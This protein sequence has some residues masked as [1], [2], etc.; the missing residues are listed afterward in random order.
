MKKRSLVAA[1]AMLMVS[2]IV[3]T[4]STY[5]WFATNNQA[6][7]T[8]FKADVGNAAGSVYISADKSNWKS[9]LTASDFTGITNTLTPVSYDKEND[10]F[11]GGSFGE[12]QNFALTATANTDFYTAIEIYVYAEVA[13]TVTITPT[14][15]D[16]A[17]VPY[18]YASVKTDAGQ[19]AIL[20]TSGDK[21]FPV[22]AADKM[23]SAT[24]TDNNTQNGIIDADEAAAGNNC[25]LGAEVA[26]DYT[27]PLTINIGAGVD[28]AQKIVVYVW[29][30]GQD[31]NCV[32]TS[33]GAPSFGISF[34][35]DQA[36]S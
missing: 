12:N 32:G 11:Y 30:E 36:D 33:S 35:Y 27:T 28:N 10:H 15:T 13:G 2:A 17:N 19:Q 25:A 4:S 5:A 16:I 26:V 3:L 22:V 8:A 14:L 23:N 1:L 24:A 20:G 9:T 18:V 7:L 6:S 34:A 21:Y 29:A 31:S